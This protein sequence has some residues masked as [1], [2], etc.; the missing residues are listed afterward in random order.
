MK[1]PAFLESLL[2]W[3]EL[4]P[5]THDV[6]ACLGFDFYCSSNLLPRC[7]HGQAP[8]YALVSV[9][10]TEAYSFHSRFELML[11]V[12]VILSKTGR[13]T[14]PSQRPGSEPMENI[15]LFPV[16]LE[17]KRPSVLLLRYLP[18]CVGL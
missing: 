16:C 9:E 4:F 6:G 3:V 13:L 12:W 10:V 17:I 8:G 2:N 7:Y 15:P 5:F 1:F 11:R 14:G 18:S